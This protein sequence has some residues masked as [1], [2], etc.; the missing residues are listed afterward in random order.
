[1]PEPDPDIPVE[2][3]HIEAGVPSLIH[4]PGGC[5]FH[6]R[7]PYATERCKKE[8]PELREVFEGHFVACHLTDEPLS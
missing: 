4:P 1:M 8:A 7:C 3:N 2:V 6:P 5:A